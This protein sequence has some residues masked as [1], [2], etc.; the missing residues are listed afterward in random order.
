MKQIRIKILFL[1]K[2]IDNI[3]RLIDLIEKKRSKTVVEIEKSNISHKIE[4]L[5]LCVSCILCVEPAD[6]ATTQEAR[7]QQKAP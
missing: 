7:G 6:G 3:R 4:T 5:V 1:K 2:R